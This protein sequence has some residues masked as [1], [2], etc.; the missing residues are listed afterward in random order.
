ML[1][2]VFI[3]ADRSLGHSLS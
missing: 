2:A 1:F 3:S